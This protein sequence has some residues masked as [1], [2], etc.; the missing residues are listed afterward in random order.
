L[1]RSISATYNFLGGKFFVFKS[2]NALKK[3]LA[4]YLIL[5]LFIMTL[6][7]YMMHW[8][9][10]KLGWNVYFCKIFSE[11]FLFIVAFPQTCRHFS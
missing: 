8:M 9:V 1:S 11:A 3:E 10:E 2:K 6:S 4:K 7:V 5:A